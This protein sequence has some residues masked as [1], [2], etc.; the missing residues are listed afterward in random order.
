MAK[1]LRKIHKN[2]NISIA[3]LIT[4][5]RSLMTMLALALSG[6][7]GVYEGGFEC[8]SGEGAGCKSISEVNDMI[9]RR[10]VLENRNQEG[11][12]DNNELYSNKE[13]LPD[14]SLLTS[15]SRYWYAPWFIHDQSIEFKRDKGVYDKYSL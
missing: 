6:C 4:D 8:P 9:N 10:Q 12:E 11:V 13:N 15:E 5:T 1:T 7:M 2:L 3:H 14:S